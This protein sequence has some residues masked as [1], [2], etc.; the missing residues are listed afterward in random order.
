MMNLRTLC[1]FLLT[2][3]FSLQVARAE[4]KP[5]AAPIT[6]KSE[7]IVLFNG[8]DL[9]SFYTWLQDTKLEDP[10]RVFTVVDAI[11]GAPAIRASGDGY[12]GIIT[13]D[14]YADYHLICEFRWGDLT[15]GGRKDRSKDSGILLHCFGPDGMNGNGPWPASVEC[16]IIEGGVG[17]LLVVGGK[18]AEG[19]SLSPAATCEVAKDRDGETIWKKGGEKKTFT[20]GRVNWFGRDPD[21]KDVLGIRGK[22]DVE[23]PGNKWTRVE[24]IAKKDTLQ[25]IVNGVIV[26]EATQVTPAS[27]KLLFQTEGAEIYFRKIELLPLK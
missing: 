26:N 11:D 8:K 15:W 24:V 22:D 17:D 7:P 25:Y 3:C 1:C 4:D 21:W 16:Q 27:G 14:E 6:P 12:G 20:G 19:K 23:S 2:V 10:R 18:D 13:K 9:A 5:K